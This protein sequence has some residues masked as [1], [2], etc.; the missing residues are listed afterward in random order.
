MSLQKSLTSSANTL[1]K[2]VDSFVKNE[3]YINL[4]RVAFI[5]YAVFVEKVPDNVIHMFNNFGVRLFV[6]VMIAYLLFKDVVTAL[7]L[8]LCFILSVQ[9]L[10]K[11]GVTVS[12]MMNT[13][14]NY[15]SINNGVAPMNNSMPSQ[16]SVNSDGD[17][18]SQPSVFEMPLVRNREVMPEDVPDPAFRT[19]TQNIVEGSFTTDAQFLDAQSNSVQGADPDTGIK[20]FVNQHGSQGLDVPLGRDPVASMHSAF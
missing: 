14:N 19:M 17:I 10:K 4:V 20:T 1:D 6:T 16:A 2:N 12:P 5:G 15:P 13:F 9:E 11:R 7:L 18:P 8:A 3:T